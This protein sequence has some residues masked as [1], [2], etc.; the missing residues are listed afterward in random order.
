MGASVRPLDDHERI[1]QNVGKMR[2]GGASD[3]EIEQ[4][5][6]QSE[7]L[8]PVADQP[9]PPPTQYDGTPATAGLVQSAL[10]GVMGGFAEKIAAGADAA[11]SA[12][13]EG[14]HSPTKNLAPTFAAAYD[15]NLSARRA[16]LEQF[17]HAH[18][19][20]NTATQIVA[21]VAPML[22]GNEAG[23]A[24]EIQNVGK[25]GKLLRSAN[26]GMKIGAL[27]GAGEGD[28]RGSLSDYL[29][30]TAAGA[31]AGGLAGAVI[32]PVSEMTGFVGRKLHVPEGVSAL[33]DKAASLFPDQSS[34]QRALQTLARAVGPRGGAATLLGSRAQ[35][36]VAGGFV[37]E[38]P[39]SAPHAPSPMAL[40]HAG[41]NVIGLAKNVVRSRGPAQATIRNALEQRSA[42]MR[43]SVTAAM[44][45]TTGVPAGAGMQPTMD[46]LTQRKAVADKLYQA[47]EETTRDQT[48]DSPAVRELMQTPAGRAS[49]A[50]AKAQRANLQ[51]PLPRAAVAGGDS[52][53][54]RQMVEMG[55]PREKAVAALGDRAVGPSS[56]EEV[57]DYPTLHLMKQNL[58]KLAKLGE[59]DGQQGIAAAQAKGALNLWGQIREELPDAWRQADD[60]YAEHSRLLDMMDR[61]RNVFRTPLNPPQP[62]QRGVTRSLSGL[63]AKVSGASPDEQDALQRGAGTAAHALWEQT[64]ASVASPG[65]VFQRSPE[66]L[67]QLRYAFPSDQAAGQFHGTVTAWDRA[68][69]LK[70]AVLGGSDTFANAAEGAARDDQ[71]M[72]TALGHLFRGNVGNALST[73]ASGTSRELNDKSR[74]ALDAEVAKIL[75]SPE[76]QALVRAGRTAQLRQL[77]ATRLLRGTATMVS[78]PASEFGAKP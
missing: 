1:R 57:P 9:P 60:A 24:T 69:A 66:R 48:A 16:A 41:P 11:G 78:E 52:P 51:R 22:M 64:P 30:K 14:L 7:G 12:V 29:D 33:A 49:F 15:K 26:M 47:A 75:T 4:Y 65:R 42:Q 71:S 44:E 58:A 6:T 5:L 43:P 45:E 27:H 53:E 10:H 18:P 70:Q 21:G 56:S 63:A 50:V 3:A 76:A 39:S 40:D 68:Q 17:D 28:E 73:F 32:A 61:G 38:A 37:P 8:R 23:A 67:Q 36:D 19:A 74:Q 72:N 25:V 77:I 62:G 31:A 20:L 59:R 55:V 34:A 2:A 54:L 13:K 46:A 35:Q